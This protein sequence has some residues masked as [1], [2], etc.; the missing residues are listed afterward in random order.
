[1]LTPG[2]GPSVAEVTLPLTVLPCPKAKLIAKP[3]MRRDKIHLLHRNKEFRKV[4]IV[5]F[6]RLANFLGV[7]NINK[8]R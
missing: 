1:M 7:L 2:S 5:V 4:P 6:F 8:G 3:K